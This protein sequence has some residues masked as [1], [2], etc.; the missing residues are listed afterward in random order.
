MKVMWVT[1]TPAMPL[2]FLAGALP[3]TANGQE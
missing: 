1:I 3:F 2:R